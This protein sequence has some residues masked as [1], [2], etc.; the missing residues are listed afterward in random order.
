MITISPRHMAAVGLPCNSRQRLISEV[1]IKQDNGHSVT[2][3][4]NTLLGTTY[5]KRQLIRQNPANRIVVSELELLTGQAIVEQVF[6]N[7]GIPVDPDIL[8]ELAQD[9]VDKLVTK[10]KWMYRRETADTAGVNVAENADGEVVVDVVRNS[11]GDI[12]KGGKR[13]IAIQLYQMY[14]IDQGQEMTNAE[15]VQLLVDQ[16]DMTVAGARTYAYNTD[17]LFGNKLVKQARGRKPK[18]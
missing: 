16:A 5:G 15:F 17:K 14:V 4:I 6:D 2:A 10:H 13:E 9:R 11:D 12:K 8:V 7:F 1:R 18:E 3:L